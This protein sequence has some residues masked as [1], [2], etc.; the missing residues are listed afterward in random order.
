[1]QTHSSEPIRR[2]RTELSP[3]LL[4][5]SMLSSRAVGDHFKNNQRFSLLSCFFFLT[6]NKVSESINMCPYVLRTHARIYT[7][8]LSVCTWWLGYDRTF[9]KLDFAGPAN[10]VGKVPLLS[11]TGL[12]FLQRTRIERKAQIRACHF[13]SGFTDARSSPK[14]A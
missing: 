3:H 5:V 7:Y 2:K 6:R 4:W 9:R 13:S 12:A 11:I 14:T 8:I 1:M 10:W